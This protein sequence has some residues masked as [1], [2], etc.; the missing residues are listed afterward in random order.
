MT[1]PLKV[2][3]RGAR[4][5]LPPGQVE[6]RKWPVLHAGRVPDVDLSRWRLSVTG[7]VERPL[8]LTWDELGALPRQATACD[9]HSRA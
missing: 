7:L 3:V 6:T 1:P 5:R 8:S 9:I 4:G 2:D